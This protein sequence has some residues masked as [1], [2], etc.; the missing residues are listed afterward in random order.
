MSPVCR[1]TLFS[2]SLCGDAPGSGC[3]L[4][5]L[6]SKPET[7]AYGRSARCQFEHP[8]EFV[9]YQISMYARASVSREAAKPYQDG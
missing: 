7:L 9:R 3:M 1:L 2:K 5:D 4:S 6:E 8:A